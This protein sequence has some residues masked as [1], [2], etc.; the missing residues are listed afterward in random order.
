MRTFSNL[1]VVTHKGAKGAC[2]DWYRIASTLMCIAVKEL[3]HSTRGFLYLLANWKPSGPNLLDKPLK[4]FIVYPVCS[5][6]KYFVSYK[7][8]HMGITTH[9][10]IVQPLQIVKLVYQLCS[11][12]WAA[13]EPLWNRWSLLIICLCSSLI[14]FTLIMCLL[15]DYD[16]L[17]LLI[18]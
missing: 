6:R 5:P 1:L 16:N 10:E 14:M 11:L 15:W 12:S 2:R 17:M 8:G 3:W 4:D 9:S 7:P 13:L 18:C